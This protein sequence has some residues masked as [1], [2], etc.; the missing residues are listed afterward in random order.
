VGTSGGNRKSK[1]LRMKVLC[2]IVFGELFA[3]VSELGAIKLSGVVE[4]SQAV[5]AMSAVYV[6]SGACLLPAYAMS[7]R[8]FRS[9]WTTAAVTIGAVLILEPVFIFA[10]FA[11]WP[12]QASATGF[13][14]GVLGLFISLT[15]SPITDER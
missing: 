1:S 3:I 7:R 11:E 6:L 15:G 5:A 2:L 10:M 14:F 8:V 9:A 13:A 4:R 12:S